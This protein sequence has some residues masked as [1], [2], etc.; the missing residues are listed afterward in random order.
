MAHVMGDVRKHTM[1]KTSAQ[2][3]ELL[4]TAK[5]AWE[6]TPQLQIQYPK[7]EDFR[8]KLHDGR[9]I[10]NKKHEEQS[11]EDTMAVAI[12]YGIGYKDDMV[13]MQTILINYKYV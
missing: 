12:Q 11:M 6:N 1:L 4:V 5:L 7:F 10:H 9:F 13:K 3:D 8:L 2:Q